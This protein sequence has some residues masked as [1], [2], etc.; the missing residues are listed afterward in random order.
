MPTLVQ[1]TESGSQTYLQQPRAKLHRCR[2]LLI[3]SN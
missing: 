3:A 1:H 2:C